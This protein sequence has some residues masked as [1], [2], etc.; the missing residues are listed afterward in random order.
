MIYVDE[1]D[2]FPFEIIEAGQ[3]R[4]PPV[5]STFRRFQPIGVSA[6]VKAEASA[7]LKADGSDDFATNGVYANAPKDVYGSVR[8]IFA[9][10]AVTSGSVIAWYK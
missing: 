6:S 9:K 2:G 8:G 10:I 4:L 5:G 1:V 7:Q 3:E